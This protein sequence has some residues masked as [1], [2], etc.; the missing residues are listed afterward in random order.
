[1]L[2]VD[3]ACNNGSSY[4]SCL[5]WEQWIVLFGNVQI[6]VFFRTSYDILIAGVPYAFLFANEFD[7]MYQ[8]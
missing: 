1:M 2:H 6:L 7:E 3:V 8:P 4:F 5:K